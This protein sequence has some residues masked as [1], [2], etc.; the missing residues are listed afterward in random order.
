MTTETPTSVLRKLFSGNA[1]FVANQEPQQ[2]EAFQHEQH[3]SVTLLTCCDSRLQTNVFNED[4]TDSMF[5]IRNIGNQLTV[6]CGSIDYGIRHLQTP[7]FLILGHTRC[8]AVK[9]AMGDYR[10]EPLHIVEELNGL[11]LPLQG[12][13]HEGDEEAQW[14]E[15]VERNVH[16]QV[17]LGLRRFRSRVDEGKLVVIGAVYDFANLYESGCGRIHLININGTSEREV[18][19]GSPILS[20]LDPAI[21]ADILS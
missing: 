18:I 16:Y 5:V 21:I 3:P 6:N 9:A 4:P 14:L 10:N 12:C 13:S 8:G 11:H 7:V 20:G 15:A 19:Q 17:E 2:F 1:S